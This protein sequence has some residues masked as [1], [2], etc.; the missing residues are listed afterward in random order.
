[1]PRFLRRQTIATIRDFWM[2]ARGLFGLLGGNRFGGCHNWSKRGMY[3]F[4]QV[5]GNGGQSGGV[6]KFSR[7]CGV[8]P[9]PLV[10]KK[11]DTFAPSSAAV[12]LGPTTYSKK[13]KTVRVLGMGCGRLAS[14]SEVHLRQVGARGNACRALVLLLPPN[15]RK[16]RGIPPLTISLFFCCIAVLLFHC[17]TRM[18]GS[19]VGGGG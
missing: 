18:V 15:D 17:C 4:G 16:T 8:T 1:M 2:S 10:V 3:V 14:A 6:D 12:P 5:G 19:W 9:P 13:G 7:F 11:G